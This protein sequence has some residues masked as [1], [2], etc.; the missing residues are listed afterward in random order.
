[1]KTP[2]LITGGSGLLA[3]NWAMAVRDQFKVILGLHDRKVSLAGVQSEYID[4]ET[5]D[6]CVRAIKKIK[7]QLVIHTVGLTS[8]ELCEADPEL[9]YH[10]NVKLA[11]NVAYAS[12]G[13][14]VKLVHVST[15]HLYPGQDCLMDES[16]PVSPVNIYGRTKAEAES[17]VL[18]LDPN[19]LIIRTNFYGWGPAYR[20]SFSDLIIK[21]LRSGKSLTLFSDVFYTPILA[22]IAVEAVN[23]LIDRKA[24]GIYNV[25]GDDRISKYEFG[26]MVLKIFKLDPSYISEGRLV[27]QRELVLRPHDMSLSNQKACS[28]LCRSLGGVRE[29]LVRLRQQETEGIALEIGSVA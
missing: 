21:A 6:T 7:P 1:M 26:L 10:V 18:D 25:V 29:H 16:H 17:R 3:L 11:E 12:A 24:C 4:L 8:V 27:E 20:Q 5:P 9:A 13:C 22:E 23:D 2:I 19:A 15:D 14:G 28:L